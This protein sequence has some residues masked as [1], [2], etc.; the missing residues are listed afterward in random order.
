VEEVVEGFDEGL[1]GI[2]GLDE[3]EGTVWLFQWN[4]VRTSV[5]S[6]K[7]DIANTLTST[8]MVIC[9]K[10]GGTLMSSL[11][12]RPTERRK[13]WRPYSAFAGKLHGGLL[14]A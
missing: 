1:V 10:S 14:P 7:G 5:L 8:V 3:V 13:S 9:M 6:V 4:I 11:A 2:V 12:K